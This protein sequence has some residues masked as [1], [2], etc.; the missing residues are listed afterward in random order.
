MARFE[1]HEH[2][3]FDIAIQ[4]KRFLA[5][6]PKCKDWCILA[7]PQV[8]DLD[9]SSKC[10][11]KCI[12]CPRAQPDFSRP[13]GDM[14]IEL[15][16]RIAKEIGFWNGQASGKRAIKWV[17]AHLSGESLLNPNF[18]KYVNLLAQAGSDVAVSTNA[19]PLTESLAKS[20]L[21]SGLHR[22]ILSVDGVTAETY[23]KIRGMNFNTMQQNV[24]GLLE[25]ARERQN[26]GLKN[27][28]IWLQILRMAENEDE[29][30]PFVKKYSG[31]ARIKSIEKY[32]PIEGLK[33][34]RVFVKAVER[35]GGQVEVE[36]HPGWD[37][38][39][40]RRATCMKPWDRLSI[41][42][43]GDVG[44]CCYDINGKVIVG[45][46]RRNEKGVA[47]SIHGI[48]HG[49]PMKKIREVMM[50]WQKSGG[51]AGSLPEL[52]ERC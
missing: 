52:C 17:W 15:A 5:K 18:V 26:W 20:V 46:L 40:N 19:I 37:G 50:L 13:I 39:A 23:E 24:D 21:G 6:C 3:F 22:L 49:E 2:G 12:M 11:G 44:L 43:N 35:F 14:D 16:A 8:L 7:M 42:W 51:K 47:N 30:L 9:I 36:R 4:N 38:A 28:Q 45:N 34:G 27:P 32:R 1:C 25:I 33:N 10:M 29:W 48:W 31:N 41:F